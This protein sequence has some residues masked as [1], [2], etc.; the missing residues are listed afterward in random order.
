MLETPA[1]LTL[2]FA[3]RYGAMVLLI[4]FVFEGALV[5]KLLPTRGLLI[6]VVVAA[7]T[8]F[9]TYASVFFAAVAGATIGQ[10]LLF[11]AVRR[12]GFDPS[13][14]NW[15]PVEESHLERAE[16]WFDRW[17]SVAVA[18]SNTLPVV[19]GSMTVPTAM[20]RVSFSRFATY[21]VAGSCLYVGGLLALAVGVDGA[22]SSELAE[23]AVVAVSSLLGLA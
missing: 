5:G 19:R 8:S 11:L 1:E 20:G 3:D 14:H 23:T 18:G 4:L 7:G 15:I 16:C 12:L 22:L 10:L 9:V 13:T 6:A 17:G 21:S 2:S